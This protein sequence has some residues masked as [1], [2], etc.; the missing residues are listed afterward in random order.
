MSDARRHI[1]FAARDERLDVLAGIRGAGTGKALTHADLDG[2]IADLVARMIE[3][4]AD[5]WTSVRLAADFTTTSAA[6]VN[7]TGLAFGMRANKT[8][9]IEGQF[10]LRTGVAT[11]AP[12]PGIAWPTGLTDGVAELRT[13][14]AAATLVLQQGNINAAVLS[15]L[16]GLPN[17]TQSWPGSLTA[18]VIAGATPSG[19]F[20]VQLASE[21]AGTTVT[22]KAGSWLRYRTI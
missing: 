15:P 3:A 12:R 11:D 19:L 14:S 2:V 18:T 8:Y 6:A 20:Q 9:L 1:A 7:V 10:L 16:G 22:M 5:R 17:T 4:R 13:T 21:T